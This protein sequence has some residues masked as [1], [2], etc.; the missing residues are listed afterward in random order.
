MSLS[1]A[2]IRRWIP[3]RVWMIFVVAGLCLPYVQSC[4]CSSRGGLDGKTKILRKV[5]TAKGKSLDPHRQFDAASSE[6]V[7]LLFDS[8]FMTH[9]LKRPYEF[10]PN[11]AAQMPNFSEDG[12]LMTIKLREDVRFQDGEC[13]A[14]GQGRALVAHDVIYS[15]MRFA[16]PFVNAN[17]YSL[18]EGLIVGLDD[19]RKKMQE[20]GSSHFQYSDFSVEGLRATN[21]HTIVI[22]L[23][24]ATKVPMQ[25]MAKSIT[26]IVPKECIDK[27]GEDFQFH[28]LGT[29]AF[30][31]K[32]TNRLGDVWLVRNPNYHLRYPSEGA[33]G[34]AESGL[35]KNAGQQLPLVDEVYAPV[36][37]ESQPAVL[38]FLRGY[39]DWIG[40]DADAFQRMARKT[41]EGQ[42]EVKDR[43]KNDVQLYAA[44]DSSSF[45]ITFN[46]KNP[47]LGSSLK[48]RKAIALALNRQG[49]VDDIL[50][51]R[52]VVI[53]TVVPLTLPSNSQDLGFVWFGRDIREA[54]RLLADAGF[55]EG[56][57][58]PEF[59]YLASSGGTTQRIFEHHRR[60][61]AEIG[62]KII[63]DS[64]P[65]SS[66]LGKLEQ[67]DFDIT[68][69]GWGADYPDAENF[70]SLLTTVARSQGQNYGSFFNKR[71]D[72]L[73][74]LTK[75]TPPGSERT[76][77]FREMAEIVKLEVPIVP[78]Y[79]M[80]RV[81]LYPKAWVHNFKRDLEGD[82]EPIHI[83]IDVAKQKKGFS[84]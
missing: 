13:F 62:V 55:P 30:R 63:L 21:D 74:D 23:T 73:S 10:V 56:K 68:T 65:Y 71:Y 57:G 50:N 4:S 48:L 76:A 59:R 16:D 15:L 46:L 2:S 7:T 3:R 45:W 82:R 24:R 1:R 19:A 70:T 51:G 42:F 33:P 12:T 11:L 20:L 17:S 8:L 43:Y 37:E 66:F 18:I 81:G 69:S 67:G 61:L 54:R 6:V 36:I 31:L 53:D 26:S 77:Y 47:T 64:M 79:G 35:L 44:M 25:V 38:K 80:V 29:G 27:Y 9:Y 39:F 40:L 83:D 22:K 28:P 5:L 32:Y 78:L 14:N 75:I 34:D 52:G 84:L 49:F 41:G 72:Q 60:S 58:L